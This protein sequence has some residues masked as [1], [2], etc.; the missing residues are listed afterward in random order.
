MVWSLRSRTEQPEEP[1][2]AGRRWGDGVRGG[3]ALELK[4]EPL[5]DVEWKGG[6]ALDM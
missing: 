6:S 5:C 4:S 2:R 3:F 1:P